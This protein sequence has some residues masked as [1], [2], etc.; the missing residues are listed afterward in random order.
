MGQNG[1]HPGDHVST[2]AEKARGRKWERAQKRLAADK[3]QLQLGDDADAKKEQ[4]EEE[5]RDAIRKELGLTKDGRILVEC[6]K[7]GSDKVSAPFRNR[8]DREEQLGW[9]T[10]HC[11]TCSNRWR[12]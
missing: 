10:L 9:T 5:G 1:E 7:C 12:Q 3:G 2:D 4:L 6:P 8:P 11:N